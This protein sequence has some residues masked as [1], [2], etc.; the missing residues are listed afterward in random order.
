MKK[1]LPILAFLALMLVPWTSRA[2]NTL[3][4][5]DG[6]A[7]NTYIPVYGSYLDDFI[8]SQFIYSAE[9]ITN[10]ITTTDMTG[11]EITSMT[12]YISKPASEA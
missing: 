5:A 10:S 7:T 4:V 9:M 11:G 6:T 8:H 12:F 2:Q 1:L 3:T